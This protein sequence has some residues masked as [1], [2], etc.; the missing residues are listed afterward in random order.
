[1][2]ALPTPLFRKR[3]LH[4][5]GVV[6]EVNWVGEPSNGSVH[7]VLSRLNIYIASARISPGQLPSLTFW[8]VIIWNHPI[9]VE[10]DTDGSSTTWLELI[11]VHFDDI[12]MGNHD[13]VGNN[14]RLGR[15]LMSTVTVSF[16][17]FGAEGR[18]YGANRPIL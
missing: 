11:P 3:L 2:S 15:A 9:S 7:L 13:I 8:R 17:P 16:M 14:P 5:L 12:G 6:T 4:G 1:M 10:G 18:T